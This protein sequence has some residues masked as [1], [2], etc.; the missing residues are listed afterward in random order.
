MNRNLI[1][2]NDNHGASIDEYGNITMITK[3][4]ADYKFEEILQR[5]N[6][7]ELLNDDLDVANSEYAD[8]KY[9]LKVGKWCNIVILLATSFMV[10]MCLNTHTPIQGTLIICGGFAGFTKLLSSSVSGFAI[11]NKKQLRELNHKIYE[12]E[13]EIPK[14]E[15]EISDIK[16]KVNY[17]T[18]S[19]DSSKNDYQELVFDN[20]CT[21]N[22]AKNVSK[23]KVL[24]LTK[25]K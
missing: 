20:M 19:D 18:L 14:L 10:G 25:S 11:I 8:R 1:E 2:Y 13:N 9:K 24:K 12:L 6:K 21:Q 23:V 4:K 17:I 22:E 3:D 16:E 5:E 15:K 7:L